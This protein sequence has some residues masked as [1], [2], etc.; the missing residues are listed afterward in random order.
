MIRNPAQDLAVAA[1]AMLNASIL[2]QKYPGALEALKLIITPEGYIG[3]YDGRDVA[4]ISLDEGAVN[5]FDRLIVDFGTESA[6]YWNA[7]DQRWVDFRDPR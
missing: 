6:R 4:P 5:G 1:Q 7:Q 3:V 2:A